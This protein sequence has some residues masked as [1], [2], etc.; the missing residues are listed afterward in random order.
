MSQVIA[1]E[2]VV[3]PQ[4]AGTLAKDALGLPQVLFCIVTGAAPLAA[5]MFNVPVAVS[6]GGYAPRHEVSRVRLARPDETGSP[7]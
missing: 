2:P 1:A 7:G 4:R 3:A 6:G 5:M